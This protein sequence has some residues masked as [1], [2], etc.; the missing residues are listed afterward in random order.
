MTF[1]LFARCLKIIQNVSFL[2]G[3]TVCLQKLAKMDH[4]WQFYLSFVHSKCSLLAMLNETFSMI[5]KHHVFVVK[6]AFRDM[7]AICNKQ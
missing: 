6:V 7:T 5:F 4:F 1:S 3:N 2:S